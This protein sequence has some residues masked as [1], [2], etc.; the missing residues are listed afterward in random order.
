MTG[1]RYIQSVVDFVPPGLPL[2]EQI[3]M[4]LRSHIAERLQEIRAGDYREG[5]AGRGSARAASFESASAGTSR[6]PP[7]P[8]HC[9]QLP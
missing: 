7:S 9:T 2:R 3:A 4:D 6:A 5:E 8:N 1:D